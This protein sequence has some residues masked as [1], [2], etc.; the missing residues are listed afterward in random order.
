MVDKPSGWTSHDVVARCRRLLGTR[1]VGHSG[2]LDPMATGVL[3][4]GV[5]RA[6]RLLNF[7]GGLPKTY[8]AEI[9]LGVETDSLD[10]DGTVT[11]TH[12]MA[13]PTEAQVAA[14]AADLTGD[15]MQ[16]PPMVSAIKIDGQRLHE[17]AR[18]GE[19]VDRPPRPVT[20]RRFDVSATDDPM[21]WRATVECSA[22]TYVR[23]L[24]AD[25][26]AALGG[27]AHLGA[28]RR[29]AV[30]PFALDDAV[31][32]DDVAPEALLPPSAIDRVMASVEVDAATAVDVGH[33]KVLGRD[34]MGLPDEAGGP[35]AVLDGAGA[36]LAVYEPH[37]GATV[38]PAFVLS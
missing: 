35:W 30:G 31:A 5:G 21:V 15:L 11:A 28:L 6:T 25:L 26:G 7:L 1:K 12:D 3:V 10:A 27:G 2:T 33:G 34:R 14:A 8:E 17:R 29:T 16:V 20:V 22:G 18:R 13:A 36:L 38:K 24:A 32:L 37:R 4:L 23:V 19:V 9:R